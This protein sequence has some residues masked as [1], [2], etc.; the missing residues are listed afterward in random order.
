MG[1][2]NSDTRFGQYLR[3]FAKARRDLRTFVEVGTW[4]GRGSTRML[5]GGLSA[6]PAADPAP[7]LLSLEADKGLHQMARDF[8][9]HN[10]PANVDLRLVY[11][12]LAD[13]MVLWSSVEEQADYKEEMRQW[14]TGEKQIFSHAPLARDEVPA[15]VDF[16]LLDGGEFTTEGD[17][18][19]LRG[20]KPRVVALGDTG[21]FKCRAI[22]SELVESGDWELLDED[23]HERTGWAVFERKQAPP[24]P[25]PA[26]P[27]PQPWPAPPPQPVP[28]P[29]P[30]PVSEPEPVPEPT[31]EPA[32]EPVP[33]P[34]PEPPKAKVTRKY[35]ARKPKVTAN[36]A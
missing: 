17:W 15:E 36:T 24:P 5:A 10:K 34:V 33:E 30:E 32:P 2:I 26:Q 14:W 9:S 22:K 35:A 28:E 21:C 25:L 31:P 27:A 23:P 13:T 7:L 12:R 3:D 29:A 11:G 8:W 16:V 6:R 19:Y 20:L 18:D 4:D 1:Q